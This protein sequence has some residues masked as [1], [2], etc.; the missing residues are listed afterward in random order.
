[1]LSYIEPNLEMWLS[2]LGACQK[3]GNFKLGKYA[4]DHA[5]SLNP[6]KAAVYVLMSNI[7]E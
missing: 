1:M 4:F 3:H 7:W 2:L 5:V 6:E